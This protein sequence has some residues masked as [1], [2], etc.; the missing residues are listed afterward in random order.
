LIAA[1]LLTL[2]G[3]ALTWRVLR[4]QLAPML[5][6]LKTLAYLSKADTHPQ[7]LPVTSQD[8]VGDLIR[9][10]NE[11]L[12]ML[13][14]RNHDLREAE[15]LY[16]SLANDIS[17][18]IWKSDP[19]KLR[20][21][22]NDPWLR[23]T[24]RTLSQ[25][26][27]NGWVEG[28]HPDD[29]ERCLQ[30]YTSAF[31]RRL[32]FSM[33]YRL[34]HADG[35]YHWITDDGTSMF[36]S[37]GAFLGYIGAC[38]DISERKRFEESLRT[39][40]EKNRAI[41]LNASDGITIMDIDGNLVDCSESFC[42]M[43][44]YPREELIGMNVSRWD[45][46][47][48]DRDAVLAAVRQQ[49]Q[50][51]VRAEFESRH[52]RRDGSTYD[53]EISGIPIELEGR[54]VLINASRDVSQ[55][56]AAVEEIRRLNTDLEQR[57][58]ERTAKLDAAIQNLLREIE[59]RKL[60]EKALRYANR[61]LEVFSY[62]VA[63]DL[64]TPLRGISSFAQ[65]IE[66]DYAEVVNADGRDALHRIQRAAQKMGDLIDGLL[67]LSRLTRAEMKI[68]TVDL[69]LLAVAVIEELSIVEPDRQV[70]IEI[71][72]RIH[73]RGDKPLLKVLLDNLLGNAWKFTAK[74]PGARIEFGVTEADGKPVYFVRDNGAGFD[75][76]HAAHL[77][78]PFHRLHG[79][80]DFAG[81]GIGLASV[82]RVV[83]R[84]GG[85]VWA[86]SAIDK[87]ASFYFTL[88]N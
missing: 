56:K 16:R 51:K 50:G 44:G 11:L 77:F 86:D 57:V 54:P 25:E 84:H 72:P 55:R 46:G 53:V 22:F 59:E 81:N 45:C 63:H 71:A 75:M 49:I 28:V 4:R 17:T 48:I 83:R 74:R 76:D 15:H 42:R 3:S 37:L 38:N 40:S 87:G 7:P 47:F 82:L 21:F 2:L 39:E 88:L 62:S 36:D 27:G 52:R 60:V 29:R 23:F 26:I 10:F 78:R 73:V 20:Y 66:Q 8:E 69:S 1:T 6:T 12:E 32:P 19:A 24:G 43:L 65:V 30:V 61:E 9:G 64:R 18:L 13:G 80:G 14:K 31:D 34:R 67:M 79:G 33:E 68:E 70:S 58:I 41:L 5:T 85:R 35:T